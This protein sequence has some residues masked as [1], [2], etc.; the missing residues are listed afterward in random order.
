MNCNCLQVN[1]GQNWPKSCIKRY[2]K[3]IAISSS[4]AIFSDVS[5]RCNILLSR[6]IAIQNAQPWLGLRMRRFGLGG[7]RGCTGRWWTGT[8]ETWDGGG[9]NSEA[10]GSW[11][12]RFSFARPPG[13]ASSWKLVSRNLPH[14]RT[15]GG[16]R[17]GR[18]G[19]KELEGAWWMINRG[20]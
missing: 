16:Q 15:G 4:I 19:T 10:E 11:N 13:R 7:K 18:W 1:E 12:V 8:G 5:K 6:Y 9:T 2:R 17:L 3:N 20:Y 14:E